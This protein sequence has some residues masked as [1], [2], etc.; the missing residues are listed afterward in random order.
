MGRG[1]H[2]QLIVSLKKLNLTKIELIK[3]TIGRGFILGVHSIVV[4]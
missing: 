1:G 4:Q 2:V 3:I